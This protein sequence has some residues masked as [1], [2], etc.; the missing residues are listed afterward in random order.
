[1]HRNL[2]SDDPVFHKSN[3][4]IHQMDVGVRLQTDFVFVRVDVGVCLKTDADFRHVD[5]GIRLPTGKD[6]HDV[7]IGILI[8]GDKGFKCFKMWMSVPD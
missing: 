7:N 6:I 3:T 8:Q 2:I 5:V 4:D 1:M